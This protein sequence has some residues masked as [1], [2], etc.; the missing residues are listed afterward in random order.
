[1]SDG[2]RAE[3]EERVERLEAAVVA[4]L[5]EYA[6]A[7][8]R[9]QGVETAADEPAP[10]DDATASGGEAAPELVRGAPRRPTASRDD[11]ATQEEVERA[12]RAFEEDAEP[13]REEAGVVE[14]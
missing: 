2:R 3:L 13:E 10:V 7:R 8:T 1:M 5:G 12:V 14:G 9:L 4:L 6:A 11:E